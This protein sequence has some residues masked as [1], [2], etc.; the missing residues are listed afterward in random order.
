M[1]CSLVNIKI[2]L[3][4]HYVNLWVKCLIY[5]LSKEWASV[6]FAT[7]LLTVFNIWGERVHDVSFSENQWFSLLLVSEVLL[8]KMNTF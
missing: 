5:L 4:F 3:Y 2:Y 7:S 1:V 6:T 8:G